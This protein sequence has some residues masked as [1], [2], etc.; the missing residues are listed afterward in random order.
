MASKKSVVLDLSIK[1]KVIE[2]SENDEFSVKEIVSK[3]NVVETQVELQLQVIVYM[4]PPADSSY[5]RVP[6]LDM[7]VSLCLF[8]FTCPQ[9]DMV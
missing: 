3:S 2:A 7:F 8:P 5:L 1:V 9:H 4:T 6:K